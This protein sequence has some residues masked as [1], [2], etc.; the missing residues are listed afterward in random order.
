[1]HIPYHMRTLQLALQLLPC[2]GCSWQLL[3]P[4]L[5]LRQLRLLLLLLLLLQLVSSRTSGWG[6]YDRRGA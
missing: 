4:L 1:M 3:G 5:L 2:A 6:A